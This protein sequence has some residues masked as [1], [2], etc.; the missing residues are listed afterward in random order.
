M[1]A[2]ADDGR[3]LDLPAQVRNHPLF[4]QG[5][6]RGY[7]D[8]ARAEYLSDVDE[9]RRL[10]RTGPHRQPSRYGVTSGGL[11]GQLAPGVQVVRELS[12]ITASEITTEVPCCGRRITIPVPDDEVSPAICCH[13]RISYT[14]CVEEEEPDGYSDEPAKVAVF[15]VAAMQVAIAQHRAG[16]WEFPLA[17][18][19]RAADR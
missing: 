5:Y 12:A 9:R 16:R 1:T 8:R 11:L 17:S 6:E 13:C 4:R 7:A 14:V 19:G 18:N 3:L 15:A 10:A 2:P